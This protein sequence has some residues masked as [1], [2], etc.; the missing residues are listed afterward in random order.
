MSA[1]YGSSNKMNTERVFSLY[2]VNFKR[3]FLRKFSS[4]VYFL[5]MSPASDLQWQ[6]DIVKWSDVND[7]HMELSFINISILQNISI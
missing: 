2:K 1:S 7:S 6:L 4:G 3:K 5:F